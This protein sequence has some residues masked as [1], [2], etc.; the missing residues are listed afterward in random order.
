MSLAANNKIPGILCSHA[1][2]HRIDLR[3]RLT[4]NE[5]ALHP[6]TMQEVPPEDQLTIKRELLLEFRR[7]EAVK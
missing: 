4:E 5:S 2:F 6:L 1:V 7:I 3:S